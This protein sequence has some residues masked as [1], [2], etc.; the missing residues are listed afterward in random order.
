MHAR[1]ADVAQ[2]VLRHRDC[3]E[4]DRRRRSLPPRAPGGGERFAAMRAGAR[5]PLGV[6]RQ[7]R[8]S[9]AH[10]GREP[11]EVAH[12]VGQ[13]PLVGPRKP[14]R[15]RSCTTA[16]QARAVVR[17]LEL[18]RELGPAPEARAWSCPEASLASPLRNL[19]LLRLQPTL[20]FRSCGALFRSELSRASRR[21]TCAL[22]LGASAPHP[23]PL[24]QA[25][26]YAPDSTAIADTPARW[27]DVGAA[28]SV[29]P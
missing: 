29:S 17:R 15:R 27:P 22:P 12:V 19:Q 1:Y 6:M 14:A 7:T 8:S 21:P 24:A 5:A 18:L 28:A 9:A 3:R 2:T 13:G 20:V 23:S 11:A 26:R 25:A 10:H 4:R 16:G